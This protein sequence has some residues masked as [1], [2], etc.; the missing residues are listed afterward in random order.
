MHPAIRV[1]SVIVAI[2]FLAKPYWSTVLFILVFSLGSLVF[3]GR[4]VIH[5]SLKM[6]RRLKWLYLSIFIVYGWFTPGVAVIVL[7][8]INPT[9]IPTLEGLQA[10]ALRVTVLI[11]IV[12][13]VAG[14]LQTTGKDK[15]VSAIIW[16]ATPLMVIGLDVQ[17]FALLLVL[18]LDNVL[19]SE[20][21]MRQCLESNKQEKAGLLNTASMVLTNALANIETKADQESAVEIELLDISAP[22]LWQW[23]LPIVLATVLYTLSY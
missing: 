17:R 22:P 23:L 18:T 11:A 3:K 2:A 20:T 8:G 19:L 7:Q 21:I 13:M 1:F 5:S 15:L 10:G 6:L 14:L 16:L 9:Y 12:S 4:T